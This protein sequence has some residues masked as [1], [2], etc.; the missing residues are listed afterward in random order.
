MLIMISGPNSSGAFIHGD[1]INV[2]G[3]PLGDKVILTDVYIIPIDAC[4]HD[5][6]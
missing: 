5:R 1:T 4:S 6:D 2:L 3:M